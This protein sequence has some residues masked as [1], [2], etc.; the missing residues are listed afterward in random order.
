MRLKK[1]IFLLLLFAVNLSPLYSQILREGEVI[2]QGAV[3]YSLPQTVVSVTVTATK[4]HFTPGIYAPFAKKYLGQDAKQ[5][6][7]NSASVKRVVLSQNAEADPNL[8][9]AV[10]IGTSKNASA[11]FLDFCSQ[12]LIISPGAFDPNGKIVFSAPNHKNG[13]VHNKSNIP[14]QEQI[15]PIGN[16]KTTVYKEVVSEDGEIEKV[17]QQVV[18]TQQKSL[19]QRAKETAELI[20]SLREK[21]VAILTGDTDANYEGN[22]M[23]AAVKE[24]NALDRKLLKLFYGT[25]TSTTQTMTFYIVP[26]SKKSSQRYVICKLSDSEGLLPA[27][28]EGGKELV[29]VLNAEEDIVSTPSEQN[30]TASK[31]KIVY[32]TPVTANGKVLLGTK[33]LGV[34]RVNV[35]QFGKIVNF[36]IELSTGK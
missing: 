5:S 15:A 21:K 32:R 16:N 31:G 4:K 29:L 13:K 24:M 25:T 1:N 14:Q 28:A 11:N 10:N 7:A 6:E 26:D 8:T 22:A 34:A 2:P 36:P 19:E 17:A 23:G 27:N 3:I 30:I 12:G 18:Q 20:F 35:F 33:T 9:I